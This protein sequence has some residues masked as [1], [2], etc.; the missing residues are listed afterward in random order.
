MK[1]IVKSS[2]HIFGY[3][4]TLKTHSGL[5]VKAIIWNDFI[6]RYT[7]L[8]LICIHR[9]CLSIPPLTKP[10]PPPLPP[11]PDPPHTQ[12]PSPLTSSTLPFLPHK[13]NLVNFD[14]FW[15]DLI[16]NWQ[17][18]ILTFFYCW[19]IQFDPFWTDLIQKNK[20]TIFYPHGKCDNF[21]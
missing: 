19:E 20:I 5:D 9:K 7:F 15:T 1:N 10:C 4:N 6:Y 12:L 14:L 17:L 21:L 8:K 13:S 11:H 3:F 2:K 18:F 16:Q